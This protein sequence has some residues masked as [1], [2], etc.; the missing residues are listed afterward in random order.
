[1]KMQNYN[2]NVN[3]KMLFHAEHYVMC[4]NITYLATYITHKERFI[5]LGVFLFSKG[6]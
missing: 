1:M 5:S 6:K 4:Y 2:A 3:I